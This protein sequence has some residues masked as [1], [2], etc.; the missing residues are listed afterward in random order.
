MLWDPQVIVTNDPNFY[1]SVVERIPLW[2]QRCRRCAGKRVYLAPHLPFGWFDYPPGAQSPD[3]PGWLAGSCYPDSSARP[4][5]EVATSTA[6]FYHRE[7]TPRSSTRC[8][9]PVAPR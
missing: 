5:A 9:R 7:P 2:Q 4:A 1:A 3:R 6:L 8:S